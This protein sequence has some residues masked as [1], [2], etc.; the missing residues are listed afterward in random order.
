MT[1]REFLALKRVWATREAAF[2][3]AHFRPADDTPFLPEDF[4][5]PEARIERKAQM[6]REKADVMIERQKIDMM[7][8]GERGGVPESFLEIGRVN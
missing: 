1:P 4:I 6:L 3:N 2:H 5:T 7:T 8:T